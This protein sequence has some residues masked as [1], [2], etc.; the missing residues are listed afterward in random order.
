MRIVDKLVIAS[1]IL[2]ALVVAGSCMERPGSQPGHATTSTVSSAVA[3]ENDSL[4]SLLKAANQGFADAQ[5][6]LGKLYEEGKRVPQDYATAASWYRKAADQGNAD[7]QQKLGSLYYYGT[8]VPQ[9]YVAAVNWYKESASQGNADGQFGLGLMYDTGFGV[10]EDQVAAASWY[11]KAANQGQTLAQIKLGDA[12]EDG[13]GVPQDYAEAHKWY[14]IAAPAMESRKP[15]NQG[16]NA[17]QLFR[18][19]IAKKMTPNQIEEAQ[20]LA[21]DW[22]AKSEISKN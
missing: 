18:D 4:D 1:A 12:Y 8:G 2:S 7:A 15:T 19:N 5:L 6:Q 20:R 10:P 13:E 9:D 16:L 14:N 3:R 11:V 21:R 17:A 22:K